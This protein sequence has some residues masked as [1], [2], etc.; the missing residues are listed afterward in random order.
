MVLCAFPALSASNVALPIVQ[1]GDVPGISGSPDWSLA[2]DCQ[3]F[4]KEDL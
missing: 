3:E 1:R 4:R 2:S